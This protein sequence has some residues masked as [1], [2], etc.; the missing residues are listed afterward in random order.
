MLFHTPEFI[1]LMLITLA[2]YYFF[3][4]LRLYSL[5]IANI[6]FYGFTGIGCLAL[7]LF[8]ATCTYYIAL[9]LQGQRKR[10]FLWIAVLL[11]ICNLLFFKY[12]LFIITNLENI[13]SVELIIKN[14]FFLKLVLPI[15]ISF[16]TF[17]LIA[18]AVDVYQEKIEPCR[19]WL[20]FWVFISFFAQLIAGPIMRGK[21]L[22][23]QVKALKNIK[24]KENHI[25]LGIAYFTMGLLKKIIL[26]D[27]IAVYANDF[28]AR[29]AALT[30]T[31]GWIAAYLFAFQIF[32]DFSAYS[33]MA[34]GI[35]YLFGIKLNINF[36]TP[37]L[38]SNAS[39]FWKRWHIT[40]SSWIKDYIYIPLGGS[41]LGEKRKYLN[42]VLAM[43]I[44]GFWHGAAW[45]FVAWGIYHGLLLVIHKYYLKF[46][47]FIGLEKHTRNIFSRFLSIFLFFQLTCIG[48]VFF[49]ADSIS[50]A[51]A[52]MHS[53]LSSN[54][55]PLEAGLFN[56]LIFIAGLY[57]LHI[58]EFYMRK[59]YLKLSMLWEKHFP[60]PLRALVYT[61]IIIILILCSQTEQNSFIYFQF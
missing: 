40:L 26:A 47:R 27:T 59:N 35:G 14:I 10:L 48:W 54:P 30:G 31:E 17:Q 33:E 12:S 25:K 13:F 21:D 60:S 44:S 32:Y 9:Q 52:I 23:P 24:F 55:F 3:P 18:Y 2:I 20:V 34:V 7:F 28:F 11:N 56:Y 53:M 41:H 39:E 58:I 16:Y 29:G 51:L 8:V 45:T 15:G 36:K 4:R 57:L 6:L 5:A 19:S 37:Y 43:T 61:S 22:L 1:C 49:R 38:S 42:L 46:M 50:N